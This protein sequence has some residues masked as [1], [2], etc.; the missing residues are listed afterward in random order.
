MMRL[1]LLMQDD[2]MFATAA[3]LAGRAAPR[4]VGIAPE[5]R[6]FVGP[7]ARMGIQPA[8]QIS[9]LPVPGRLG[10]WPNVIEERHLRI[11][12][13]LG[14]KLPKLHQLPAGHDAGPVTEFSKPGSFF[15]AGH[16]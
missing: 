9:R 14:A 3:G 5:L 6:P 8:F 1:A 7:G 13:P 2:V 4:H 15:G 12:F 10:H 16:D 11:V